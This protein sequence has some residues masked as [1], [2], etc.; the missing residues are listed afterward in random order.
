MRVAQKE[1]R[2]KPGMTAKTIRDNGLSSGAHCSSDEMSSELQFQVSS[3]YE[4]AMVS[5]TG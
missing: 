1:S 5:F 2:H 3:D 4:N